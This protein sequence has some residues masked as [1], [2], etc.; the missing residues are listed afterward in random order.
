MK[1]LLW[2]FL[3]ES[4]RICILLAASGFLAYNVAYAGPNPNP[5]DPLFCQPNEGTTFLIVNGGAGVFTV[6]ADCFNNNIANNTALTIATGMGGTLT[7]TNTASST[8]YFYTPPSPTFTGLDTFSINVTTVWN[9][10]GGPGSVGG[11]SGPGST[12]TLNIT[13]N[14]IPSTTTLNVPYGVTT[15]VPV[16]AGSV[17]GCGAQGNAG[18]GPPAGTITGCV[19]GIV[20]SFAIETIVPSHGTLTVSGNT[21]QYAPNAGYSG[22]DT[23][24]Y[25]AVGI[26]TDGPN[27]LD[28]GDVTV[29]VT[30]PVSTTPVPSSILLMFVG[31]AVTGLCF[32]S[33]KFRQNEW[34]RLE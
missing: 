10:A 34:H 18:L 27:S 4:A 13:L 21:L 30:V 19:T 28:S 15:A 23:F 6:D 22:P 32:A 24:T 16:P 8:N 12:A 29:A 2:L 26:N 3:E 33:G 20:K 1:R 5:G 25:Q 14:V 31:L 11:S 7:G 9:G 17:T